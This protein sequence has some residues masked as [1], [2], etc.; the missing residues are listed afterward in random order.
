MLL[1]NLV[2]INRKTA[3]AWLTCHT[4]CIVQL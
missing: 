2:I 4:V 3:S 1:V